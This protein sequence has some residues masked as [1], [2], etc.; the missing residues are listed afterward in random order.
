MN[1]D[2]CTCVRLLPQDAPRPNAGMAW[3]GTALPRHARSWRFEQ[4]AGCTPREVSP[5]S[6]RH[7]GSPIT[8]ASIRRSRVNERLRLQRFYSLQSPAARHGPFSASLPLRPG[9]PERQTHDD[10]RHGTTTLYQPLR[11]LDGVV[12]E[13]VYCQPRTTGRAFHLEST[14]ETVTSRRDHQSVVLGAARLDVICP[15]PGPRL[16]RGTPE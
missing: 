6:I 9:V 11:A 8:R 5:I 3:P 2:V 1:K 13:G 7:R 4:C 10:I 14:S 15:R 12:I 16:R